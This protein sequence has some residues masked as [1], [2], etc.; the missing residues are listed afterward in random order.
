MNIA[1]TNVLKGRSVLCGAIMFSDLAPDV[2][3]IR[4]SSDGVNGLT[5]SQIILVL[6]SGTLVNYLNNAGLCRCGVCVCEGAFPVPIIAPGYVHDPSGD[7]IGGQNKHFE[8]VA[9]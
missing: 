1:R 7:D 3:E 2:P 8:A 4:A 9:P 6:F 5:L